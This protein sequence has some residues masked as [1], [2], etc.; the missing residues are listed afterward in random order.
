MNI[1]K[2]KTVSGRG[3]NTKTAITLRKEHLSE[4][5][6][7]I[8]EI[9]KT[10]INQTDIQKNIESFIGSVEIPSGLVGPLLYY[11]SEKVEEEEVF[12]VATTLE[13]DRKSVV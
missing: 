7:S 9:E 6:Y 13:G 5:G 4:L 12:C 2:Y 10:K 1:R 3:L 11:N 8:E